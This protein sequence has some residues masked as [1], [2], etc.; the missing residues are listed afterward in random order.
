MADTI[1]PIPG[2]ETENQRRIFR[3]LSEIRFL[4]QLCEDA[5]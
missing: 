5:P 4:K 2:M 1:S 3:R